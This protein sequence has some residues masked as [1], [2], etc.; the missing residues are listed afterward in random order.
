MIE[1]SMMLENKQFSPLTNVAKLDHN[2][3]T[4]KF[5]PFNSPY[6]EY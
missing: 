4:D 6:I 3:D 5:I 2:R 1:K